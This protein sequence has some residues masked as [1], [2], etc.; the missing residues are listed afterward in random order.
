MRRDHH[1]LV[2]DDK[3]G[4][5]NVRQI[6]RQRLP[7]RTIGGRHEDAVFGAGEQQTGAY[8]VLANHPHECAGGNSIGYRGPRGAVVI[9]APRVGSAV[10]Q[11]MPFDRDIRASRSMW[12][13]VDAADSG[14]RH[15]PWGGH[16]PPSPAAITR[17]RDDAVVRASPDGA[18]VV[19]RWRNGEDGGVDLRAVL[20]EHDWPTAVAHRRRVRAREVRADFAPRPS[21]IASLPEV[22]RP[23]IQGAG[24]APRRGKRI[25]PVPSLGHDR[26][27]FSHDGAWIGLHIAEVATAT[28]ESREGIGGSRVEKIGLSRHRGDVGA[29]ATS[30]RVEPITGWR[31]RRR[32]RFA[33]T[34]NAHRGVVLLGATDVIGH[35]IGRGHAIKLRRGILLPAPSGPTVDSNDATAVVRLHHATRIGW[36][37]P[38][39]VMIG[40][41][42]AN[43]SE[44]TA[45]IGG[46]L[47]L[48]AQYVDR[49]AVLRVGDHTEEV[50]GSLPQV[51]M[52]VDALPR[53]APVIGAMQ[54]SVVRLDVRPQ[55]ATV[56]TAHGN[57][58]LA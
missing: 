17:D 19:V 31:P 1:V 46:S 26:R 35:F 56:C 25:R 52:R 18:R 21:L 7:L 49:F 2:L 16:I 47:Q 45:T 54:S 34:R 39:V 33:A 6:Q 37:D 28:V 24:I 27:W 11:L 42:R 43:G 32:K 36:I 38:Q 41:G 23:D 22:L 13:G 30:H 44:R 20:V 9:G 57:G 4:H 3:V 10:T 8:R 58:H 48:E 53:S 5:L 14:M 15:Q 12:G 50:E 55:S 29:L 51:A 40:V